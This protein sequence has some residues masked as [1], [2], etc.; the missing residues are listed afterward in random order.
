MLERIINYIEFTSHCFYL[1]CKVSS[2][3]LLGWTYILWSIQGSSN[4]TL[5]PSPLADILVWFYNLRDT[6]S[7][8]TIL[9]N[10][11]YGSCRVKLISILYKNVQECFLIWE[12]PVKLCDSLPYT[13]FLRCVAVRTTRH[14]NLPY[15]YWHSSVMVCYTWWVFCKNE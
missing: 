6:L 7:L 10:L 5:P 11:F 14:P 13:F 12:N 15:I 8:L 1:T 2:M 3:R 9:G 4:R